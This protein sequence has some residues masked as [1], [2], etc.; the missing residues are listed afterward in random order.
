MDDFLDHKLTK[1]EKAKFLYDRLTKPGELENR[2]RLLNYEIEKFKE[3]EAFLRQIDDAVEH[4]L[5]ERVQEKFDLELEIERQKIKEEYELKLAELGIES[6]DLDDADEIGSTMMQDLDPEN[7]Q[8]RKDT[9]KSIATRNDNSPP[10]KGTNGTRVTTTKFKNAESPGMKSPGIDRASQQ[11]R[12]VKRTASNRS[13]MSKKSFR[14]KTII[15]ADEFNT[16][17]E[18][19]EKKL[20]EKEEEANFEK[21]NQFK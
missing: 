9:T 1:E 2:K 3:S 18:T 14:S 20:I 4:K 15:G 13:L 10:S 12:N 19:M 6:E 11:D 8:E 21:E 7:T 17:K 5:E 16:F